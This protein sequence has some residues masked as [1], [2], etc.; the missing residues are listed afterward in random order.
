[1]PRAPYSLRKH[2]I[3][4]RNR[5]DRPIDRRAKL[6]NRNAERFD[7]IKHAKKVDADLASAIHRGTD[8]AIGSLAEYEVIDRKQDVADH[9]REP[10]RRQ[11]LVPRH[12]SP[13]IRAPS[14]RRISLHLGMRDWEAVDLRRDQALR[15]D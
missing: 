3:A 11:A 1:M 9:A 8:L 14:G 4:K 6:L 10:N 13:A 12:G 7:G 15:R 2:V 5:P